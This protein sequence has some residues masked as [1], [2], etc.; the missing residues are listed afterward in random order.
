[1]LRQVGLLKFDLGERHADIVVRDVQIWIDR[2]MAQEEEHDNDTT[3]WSYSGRFIQYVDLN[4][5]PL[6]LRPNIST[7]NDTYLCFTTSKATNAYFNS[8]L[9]DGRRGIVVSFP[10]QE[11]DDKSGLWIFYRDDADDK[12]NEDR[13]VKCFM[14]DL[15]RKT[16]IDTQIQNST[17]DSTMGRESSIDDILKKSQNRIN[18]ANNEVAKSV[19][20]NDRRLQFN[21]TL[22]RLILGGLRL[23]GIPNTQSSF[24]R[25]YKMAFDA[26]EFT[27]RRE[28]KEISRGQQQE[29]PFEGLQETVEIL[30][31]LFTKS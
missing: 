26:S 7:N 14:L 17:K 13:Y 5:L 24:Q 31:K 27:Y 15:T 23:R 29:I 10:T 16:L 11:S 20:I 6:W 8:K 9:R 19:R 2:D 22:S 25:L 1:M 18:S 30:L 21:E 3:I 4:M 28:L 12:F